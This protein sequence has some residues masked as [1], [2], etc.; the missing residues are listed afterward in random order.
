M[1]FLKKKRDLFNQ[2]K[3]VIL[4]ETKLKNNNRVSLPQPGMIQGDHSNPLSMLMYQAHPGH[5]QMLT[6]QQQ[7][8]Q[9]LAQAPS[10]NNLPPQS[11]IMPIGA[12]PSGTN[13]AQVP[14]N[15]PESLN[16]AQTP[17]H[18]PHHLI[19][20]PSHHLSPHNSS[21]CNIKLYFIF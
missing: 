16:K 14:S 12:I 9:I 8:P 10:L 18:P 13:Q 21:N 2:L 5:P 20:P 17:F 4:E 3:K 11:S 6:P 19:A 7:T 1:F 15:G